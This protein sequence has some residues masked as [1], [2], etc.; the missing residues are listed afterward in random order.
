MRRIHIRYGAVVLSLFIL[1]S[2]PAYSQKMETV[3]GVKLIHNEKQGRWGTNP[4][5]SLEFVRNIGEVDSMDENV[6]FHMPADITCDEQGNIYVLDAG[7]Q[8]IQKFNPQGEYL[9]TIGRRGEGPGELQF[10]LSLDRDDRGYLYVPD[11]SNQ[12]IQIYTPEGAPHKG[13]SLHQSSAGIIRVLSDGSLLQGPGGLIMMGPGGRAQGET[14]PP[15]LK[16]RGPEGEVIK[17]FGE[18]KDFKDFMLNRMGNQYQFT[19]AEDGSVYVA[20]TYQNRI[21]KYSPQGKLMWSAD[22]ELNY[23]VKTPRSKGK[24]TRSGGNVRIQAPQMNQASSGIAV[25]GEGRIWVVNLVRQIKE[26]EQVRMG[27]SMTQGAGG[28]NTSISVQG[29]TDL[30]TTDMYRL[31]VYDGEGV[32]LTAVPITHF[33]DAIRIYDDKIFILDR[34]RGA[35]FYQYRILAK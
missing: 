4:K 12:R 34:M 10:P 7:N 17:E 31:E 26:E 29:N 32:L 21:D 24:M 8:R 18:S 22:R 13:I 5:L 14:P 1:G 20:F 16:V 30:T 19:V 3:D 15:L 9:A 6:L 2:I 33:A 11:S 35:Q 28:S 23:D 27:I 25:D